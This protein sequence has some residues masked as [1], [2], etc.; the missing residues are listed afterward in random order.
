MVKKSNVEK[1]LTD[2]ENDEDGL[3]FI[4]YV[5]KDFKK[6]DPFTFNDIADMIPD[7]VLLLL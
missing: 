6:S 3:T 7:K 2:I 1:F 5:A 4:S